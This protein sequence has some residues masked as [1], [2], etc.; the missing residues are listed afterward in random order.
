LFGAARAQHVEEVIRPVLAR[1]EV[2]ISDRFTDSSIAYQ[3]GGL[4]LDREFINRMNRFA[5]GGLQPNL[6]FLLDVEPATGRR[7]RSEQQGDEVTA[8]DRIEDRGL[9][10]QNRVRQVFLE[11][12]QADPQRVVVIDGSPPA[13]IVH[14]KIFRYLQKHEVLKAPAPQSQA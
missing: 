3:G 11:L 10:F 5:T 12:A 1:G 8:A 2:V 4:M 13:K 6:T 7:R 9:E 14:Q